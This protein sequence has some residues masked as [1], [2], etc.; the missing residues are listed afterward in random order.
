[1]FKIAPNPTFEHEV[2]I[3]RADG[4]VGSITFEFRH[5]TT[6]GM[7]DFLDRAGSMKPIEWAKEIIV[8]WKGVDKAFDEDAL[9]ELLQN[10]LAAAEAIFD[11]YL[12][13]LS[14]GRLGN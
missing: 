5:K 8:G 11:G 4:E 10:H 2:K 3:T 14:G 6:D 1:M 13:G 7:N 9:A 12:K